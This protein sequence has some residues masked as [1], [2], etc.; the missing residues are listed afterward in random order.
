MIFWLNRAYAEGST[1]MPPQASEFAAG[2]D[3]LYKFLIITSFISCV[4]VIG[5]L[6]YFALKYKRQTPNDKTAYISHNAMLEF[7][8]SFIPFVIF[9]IVFGWGFKIYY[10]MRKMPEN[11]QEVHVVGQK[12]YWDFLYKSGRKTSGEFYVP[13]REPVKLIISSRD[14][15]HSVFI[16][17]FRIKQD[18]VPGRYTALHF[19]ATKEGSFQFFCTEYC[20][21]GHSA[22]L[23][24]VHVLSKEKY[25]EWLQNDPYKGMSVSDIGQKVFEQKCTACHNMSAERKVGPGLG[26]IF[27][28]EHVM[29]DGT[30]VI[31]DENYLRTSILNPAAQIVA[32]YPNAMTPFQG[33]LSEQ[34][35]LGLI[36]YIKASQ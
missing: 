13:V 34:E 35:L 6:I 14:V 18:A 23:A 1:F 11:A 4:L 36:E 8:W 24:K 19:T 30:K 33:Q 31:V 12:W 10:E 29:A 17:G 26:G 9:M 5:G 7:L 3:S 2:V 25:E 28:K 16:P 20:G 21:D 15:L 22:M 32:G 27:G